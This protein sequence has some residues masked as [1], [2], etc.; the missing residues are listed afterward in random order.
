MKR[1]LSPWCKEVKKTLI[2]RDMSVTELYSSA[3]Q[4]PGRSLGRSTE[5]YK[6][7]WILQAGRSTGK[8]DA[9]SQRSGKAAWLPGDMPR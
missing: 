3:P 6:P 8:P 7:V 2:D 5:G 1:K 4:R 9:D